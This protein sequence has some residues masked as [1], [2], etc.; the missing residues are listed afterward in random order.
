[1]E[2]LP[3]ELEALPIDTYTIAVFVKAMFVNSLK[4]FPLNFDHQWS[5]D[6]LAILAVRKNEP[7]IFLR[8]IHHGNSVWAVCVQNDVI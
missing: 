6:K 3:T 5:M 8:E 4:F 1:M 7:S 2:V